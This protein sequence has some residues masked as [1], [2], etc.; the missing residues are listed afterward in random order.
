M[1]KKLGGKY[2]RRA[3]PDVKG[4]YEWAEVKSSADE[5]PE[6][7]RQLAGSLGWAYIVLPKSQHKK[8]L[9]RLARLKTGLMDYRGNIT[10]PSTRRRQTT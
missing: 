8:A 4:K 6:A 1:A 2:T 9:K 5:I 10:K 3:S 7:L